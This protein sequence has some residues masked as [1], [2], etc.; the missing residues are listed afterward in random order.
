VGIYYSVMG[1][2]VVE[3][4]P[5]ARKVVAELRGETAFCDGESI[6]AED[7]GGDVDLKPVIEVRI[8][9]SDSMSY[10]AAGAIDDAIS[11]LGPHT[12]GEIFRVYTHSDDGDET[13][14]FVPFDNRTRVFG[15]SQEQLKK[16]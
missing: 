5:E 11:A 4:T 6:Q 8:E 10:S 9:V 14:A 2:V 13:L 16:L 7:D 1:T 3:D 15:E 12:K